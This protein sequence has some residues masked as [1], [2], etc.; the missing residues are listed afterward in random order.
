MQK[1]SDVKGVLGLRYK[2][3]KIPLPWAFGISGVEFFM[4]LVEG[5][6]VECK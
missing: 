4:R 3:I 5:T 6:K 2:Y 1:L